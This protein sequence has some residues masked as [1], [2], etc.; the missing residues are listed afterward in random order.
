MKQHISKNDTSEITIF[1]HDLSVMIRV[2]KE[3]ITWSCG[4]AWIEVT[5]DQFT[6]INETLY[7]ATG[8]R[9]VTTDKWSEIDGV[10]VQHLILN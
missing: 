4:Y 3:K 7:K 10:P 5:D 6:K 9:L 1:H 8:P 2:P